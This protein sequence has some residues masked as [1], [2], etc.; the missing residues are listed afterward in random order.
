MSLNAQGTQLYF[1]DPDSSNLDIIEVDCLTSLDGLSSPLG[2]EDTTCLSDLGSTVEP[3]VFQAGSMTF[4]VRFDP[5]V[6]SHVRLYEL[7]RTKR[8]LKWAV[9]MSDGLD[10]VPTGVDSAGDI[11]LPTTRSWLTVTGYIQEFPW[12]FAI[13]TRVTNNLTIRTDGEGQSLQLKAA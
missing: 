2:E 1:L 6:E 4:T 5:A 12:T 13:G 3:T 9:G 10:I 8:K 11:T 7:Y